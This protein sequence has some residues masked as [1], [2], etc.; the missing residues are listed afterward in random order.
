MVRSVSGRMHDT[1][2]GAGNRDNVPIMQ[3]ADPYTKG[4]PCQG[5]VL[6]LLWLQ[7]VR[8]YICTR[9]Y[10][11]ADRLTASDAWGY[12]NIS[13]SALSAIS[14]TWASPPV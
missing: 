10:L 11:N 8:Y 5:G 6:L 9:D 3:L 2:R 4:L 7:V 13:M 12:L 14:M 1:Q